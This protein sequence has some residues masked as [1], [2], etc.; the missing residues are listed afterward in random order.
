M[1]KKLDKGILPIAEE[2]VTPPSNSPVKRK[3]G[4]SPSKASKKQKGQ[5]DDDE[6]N[7]TVIRGIGN[8]KVKTSDHPVE[9][10]EEILRVTRW[11]SPAPGM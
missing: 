3:A 11:G 9:E 4:P 10:D 6:E 8:V 2:S 7:E 5:V 1:R